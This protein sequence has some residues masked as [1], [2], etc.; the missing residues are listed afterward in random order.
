MI[1]CRTF[2]PKPLF[3]FGVKKFLKKAWWEKIHLAAII[4]L[5]LNINLRRTLLNVIVLFK[6]SICNF[7]NPL[8]LTV[9]IHDIYL[10]LINLISP[11]EAKKN[12]LPMN[13][14]SVAVVRICWLGTSNTFTLME[15][16]VVHTI[17]YFASQGTKTF[18]W[19]K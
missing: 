2:M 8:I 3:V 7:F 17:P 4:H 19:P 12:K 11:P 16:G 13:L 9:C 10:L 18:P 1:Q 15:V 5:I 6:G 14:K